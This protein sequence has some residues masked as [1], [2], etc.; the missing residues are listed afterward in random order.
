[1]KSARILREEGKKSGRGRTLHQPADGLDFDG[2]PADLGPETVAEGSE[3]SV[4]AGEEVNVGGGI[5]AAKGNAEAREK[6]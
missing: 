6:T 5:V 2:V 1:M 4:T 3:S